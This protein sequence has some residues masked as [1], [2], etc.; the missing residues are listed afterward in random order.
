M[1][2]VLII[3]KPC[4]N[5]LGYVIVD[6]FCSD[7]VDVNQSAYYVLVSGG[8]HLFDALSVYGATE[9]NEIESTEY[10]DTVVREIMQLREK[11]N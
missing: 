1:N 10:M 2:S 4:T 7:D 5:G 9:E 3:V 11:N 8:G 6:A